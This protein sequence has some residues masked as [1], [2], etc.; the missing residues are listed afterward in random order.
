MTKKIPLFILVKNKKGIKV[1]ENFIYDIPLIS[2]SIRA[3][4]SI[5]FI[6]FMEFFEY[7]FIFLS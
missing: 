5:Y 2:F 6:S 3:G 7:G 4:D 1:M